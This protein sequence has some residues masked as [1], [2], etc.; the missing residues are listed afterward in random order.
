M[1][2]LGMCNHVILHFKWWFSGREIF[3][4]SHY[5]K[6]EL[7]CQNWS[8]WWNNDYADHFCSLV[9]WSSKHK[10][11]WNFRLLGQIHNNHA[12]IWVTKQAPEVNCDSLWGKKIYHHHM[13]VVWCCIFRTRRF[14]L[15]LGTL[16]NV[17]KNN[18]IQCTMDIYRWIFIFNFFF[19]YRWI[20]SRGSMRL[21]LSIVEMALEQWISFVNNYPNN[22]Y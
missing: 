16:D 9:L 7:M 18:E 10:L 6:V 8:Q 14:E 15:I 17:R 1:E 20:Q 19:A 21:S 11:L 4:S 12:T 5:S 3:I 2:V 13:A 22:N